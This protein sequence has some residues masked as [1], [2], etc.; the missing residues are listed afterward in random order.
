M[1]VL[2][3]DLAVHLGGMIRRVATHPFGA[4]LEGVLR[5]FAPCEP[6]L[7]SLPLISGK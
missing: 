1:R 5:R 6:E 2:L 4:A 7:N 3:W